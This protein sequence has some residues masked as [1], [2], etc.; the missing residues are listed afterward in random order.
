LIKLTGDEDRIAAFPTLGNGARKHAFDQFTFPACQDCNAQF[1][2][3][4]ECAKDIVVRMLNRAPLSSRDILKL[5]DWIDKVR[6]S[7]WLGYLALEGHKY[8]IDPH[9]HTAS[10]IGIKD[11][12]IYVAITDAPS[13]RL[14][15]LPFADPVF[16]LMPSFFSLYVN[17][18]AIVSLSTDHVIS[19]ALGFPYY[20]IGE[21]LQDGTWRVRL[22]SKVSNRL[23]LPAFSPKF[24]MFVHAVYSD[25]VSR[26]Y[27]RGAKLLPYFEDS[28]LASKVLLVSANGIATYPQEPDLFWIPRGYSNTSSLYRE[29]ALRL[30]L[31]RRWVWNAHLPSY[32]IGP[33][34][35]YALDLA[36]VS[37][38]AIEKAILRGLSSS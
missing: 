24:K 28:G 26:E 25:R 11:R 34:S 8:G 21:V 35:E 31:V 37:L 1:S 36:E 29:M 9:F 15:F 6:T 5:M 27:L 12:A 4:E 38:P 14:S 19:E 18:L 23:R 33:S 16:A 3:L 7:V 30:L 2:T 20:S 22:E 13:R 17:G 10:R 32:R